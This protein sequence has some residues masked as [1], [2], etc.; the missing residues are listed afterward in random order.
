MDKLPPST[1]VSNASGF[2]CKLLAI[3]CNSAQYSRT[4]ARIPHNGIAIGNPTVNFT[5]T[6]IQDHIWK[7]RRLEVFC[8]K[9]FN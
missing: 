6:K 8:V 1:K 9:C 5:G 4:V 2:Y 3:P 7:I